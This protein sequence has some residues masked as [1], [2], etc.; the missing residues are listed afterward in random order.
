MSV[1]AAEL[2]RDFDNNINS[3]CFKFQ[4]GQRIQLP[5]NPQHSQADFHHRGAA[6]KQM[7]VNATLNAPYSFLVL[8]LL[9]PSGEVFSLELTVRDK[10]NVSLNGVDCAA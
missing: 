5:P 9:I 2:L 8:Q 1:G 7:S 10:Q 4:H 3:N 6:Q